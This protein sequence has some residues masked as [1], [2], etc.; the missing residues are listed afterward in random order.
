MVWTLNL[1]MWP[2]QVHRVMPYESNF[3]TDCCF[4]QENTLWVKI[5]CDFHFFSARC[6]VC[7]VSHCGNKLFCDF[8]LWQDVLDVVHTFICLCVFVLLSAWSL[9]VRWQN[10]STQLSFFFSFSQIVKG[11]ANFCLMMFVLTALIVK[12]KAVKYAIVC[13]LASACQNEYW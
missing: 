8:F 4:I 7:S 13:L 12:D 2:R 10:L 6:C 11:D 9:M 3:D 5:L 1:S